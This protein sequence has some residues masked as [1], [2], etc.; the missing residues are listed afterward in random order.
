MSAMIGFYPD[1]K[2]V[3]MSAART[4]GAL[5]MLRALALVAGMHWLRMAV[6]RYP[7]YTVDTVLL[8]TALLLPTLLLPRCLPTGGC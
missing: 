6:V 8:T 2:L 1:I 4:S 5:F 7:G 3:H